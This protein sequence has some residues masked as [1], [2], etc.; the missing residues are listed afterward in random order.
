[1]GSTG[2]KVGDSVGVIHRATGWQ[3][4]QLTFS[5]G[6][7]TGKPFSPRPPPSRH[8]PK[9][10]RFIGSGHLP[11]FGKRRKKYQSS[12]NHMCHGQISLLGPGHVSLT[13]NPCTGGLKS[14][15]RVHHHDHPQQPQEKGCFDYDSCGVCSLR[16][17]SGLGRLLV[18]CLRPYAPRTHRC[19]PRLGCC[20]SNGCQNRGTPTWL[21]KD[22]PRAPSLH[23]NGSFSTPV[24]H[25]KG[26]RKETRFRGLLLE[27]PK[28]LNNL[29]LGS[30]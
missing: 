3:R 21:P 5:Q 12:E 4:F 7:A 11:T 29:L 25:F 19:R 27:T 20:S 24:W 22:N 16:F 6:V 8:V 26:H 9:S 13:R 30:L 18:L 10:R 23:Q 15:L 17:S 2:R 28:C 14:L 1:M